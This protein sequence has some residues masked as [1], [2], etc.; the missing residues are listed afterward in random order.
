VP[1]VRCQGK[2]R[3]PTS[4]V[5]SQNRPAL[6]TRSF[7]LLTPVLKNEGDSGDVDENKERRKAGVRYQVTGVAE[8]S[9][10]RYPKSELAGACASVILT[11][12]SR[13]LLS[14]MKVTPGMLMKT[15]ER[16]FRGQVRGARCQVIGAVS[17][18]LR[19]CGAGHSLGRLNPSILTS[20]SCL[21][22][23]ALQ[24]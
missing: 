14:K 20:D 6:A 7:R 12:V 9:E 3:G 22:T 16:G 13:L 4:E 18:G 1:G 17:R 15:K 8:R 10:V 5:R 2:V 24:K 11:P 21:L 23:P 19:A